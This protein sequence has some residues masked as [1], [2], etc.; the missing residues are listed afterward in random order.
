MLRIDLDRLAREG[1][2]EVEA[3]VPVDAPLWLDSGVTWREPVHVALRASYAGSGEVVVR[4]SIRGVL[5]QECRRC[6]EPV[7]GDFLQE[8]TVAFV[9]QGAVGAEEDEGILLYDPAEALDLGRA[10]REE[11]ILAVDPYVVCD[12][13]CQGLCPRCGA[14]RNVEAC[15]CVDEELD[16]RWEALRVLKK[17]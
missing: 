12:P 11:V 2:L 15:A 1:S 16:P 9:S 13:A 3:D 4:G 14:N 17:E 10:V 6:L 5:A 7:H 8:M